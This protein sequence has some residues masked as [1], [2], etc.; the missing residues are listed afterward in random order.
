MAE[1]EAT[2]SKLELL[3]RHFDEEMAKIRT[4]RPHVSAIEDIAVDYYGT[5]T[6]VKA[7]GSIRTLD[8]HTLVVDPWDKKALEPI[9]NAISKSELGINALVESDRVRIPFPPLSEERR[10][11]FKRLA[12]KKAEEAKVQLRQIRDEEM[13]RVE[14][15]E[16]SKDEKF[17]TKEKLEKLFKEHSTKIEGLLI[18]KQQELS[19][20]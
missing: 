14:R 20:V 13:K 9:A 8:V 18:K 3:I 12:G 1:F 6:P 2:K 10:E 11:E 4:G 7:L 17:R 15:A 5:P 19:Q 16:T